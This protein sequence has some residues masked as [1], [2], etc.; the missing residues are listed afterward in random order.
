MKRLIKSSTSITSSN[1]VNF[2][3]GRSKF[4]VHI[5]HQDDPENLQFSMH[6]IKPYDDAEYA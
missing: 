1:Y 3:H 2:Q 5:S 6:V 4:G